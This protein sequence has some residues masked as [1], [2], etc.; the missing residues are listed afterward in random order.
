MIRLQCETGYNDIN[1]LTGERMN[2]GVIS[3][4]K[5]FL[6]LL[7][8]EELC[9]GKWSWPRSYKPPVYGILRHAWKEAAP[10]LMQHTRSVLRCMRCLK[11]L[12]LSEDMIS[13]IQL[14]LL[15]HKLAVTVLNR[16]LPCPEAKC[17]RTLVY[18]LNK[19]KTV[20]V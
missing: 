17:L 5:T 15:P 18:T 8:Y 9:C 19:K 4:F 7:L 6:T 20:D 12:P 1:T 11:D 10:Q 13:Q 2:M 3:G 16:A 14:F